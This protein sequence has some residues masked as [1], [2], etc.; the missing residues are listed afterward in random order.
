MKRVS[1]VSNMVHYEGHACAEDN[2]AFWIIMEELD[3]GH[4]EHSLDQVDTYSEAA[5]LQ[6]TIDSVHFKIKI[7][8]Y[9]DHD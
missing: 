3:G 7:I 2:N 8:R 9:S 1:G 5:V 6:V 4:L